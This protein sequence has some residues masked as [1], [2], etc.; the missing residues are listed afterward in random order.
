[1]A[2]TI[3]RAQLAARIRLG[4][5]QT[6]L[7]E[8]DELLAYA[9]EA[10]TKH[11]PLAPDVVHNEAVYRLAGYIYDR[12]F[13]SADTRFSNALRNSGAASALLP[14]RVHRLGLTGDDVTASSPAGAADNA[15]IDLMI[16]GGVIVATRGDGSTEDIPLPAAVGGVTVQSVVFNTT[17]LDIDVTYS[18]GSVVTIVQPK[19]LI[20]WPGA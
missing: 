3:T 10:V 12:P 20:S 13:A 6:E 15:F 7:D 5:T 18:D 14:Y 1:M 16:V 17:T 8:T 4:R 11:A 2:V 19:G 9:T